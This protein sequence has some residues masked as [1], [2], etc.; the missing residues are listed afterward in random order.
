MR[1]RVIVVVKTCIPVNEQE[2]REHFQKLNVAV[3]SVRIQKD[4]S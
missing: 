4:D 1:Q 2:I 3:E